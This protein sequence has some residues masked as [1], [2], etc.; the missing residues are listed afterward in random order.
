[1]NR[2]QDRPRV[3]RI[4]GLVKQVMM[5]RGY[6]SEMTEAA[7]LQTV[8]RVVG[9]EMSDSFWIGRLNRGTLCIHV[10][11]SVTMQEFM[12]Q[13]RQILRGVQA[14]MPERVTEI[15]FRLG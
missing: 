15:R 2:H 1:M 3:R 13:K 14:E 9:V 4:G 5:R 11:D 10:R 7:L 8:V 6:A 12:F